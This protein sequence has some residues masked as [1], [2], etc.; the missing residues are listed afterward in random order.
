MYCLTI[1]EMTSILSSSFKVFYS[2]DGTLCGSVEEVLEDFRFLIDASSDLGLVLNTR[3]C[4][5]IRNDENTVSTMLSSL[6]SLSTV[7]PAEAILLAVLLQSIQ[8]S[9][10]RSKLFGPWG[11]GSSCCMHDALCL[12]QHALA[13]SKVTLRTAP[14]YQSSLLETFDNVLQS[15]LESICNIQLQLN[16]DS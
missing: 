13:I 16:A 8:S 11:K 6:P 5:V 15:L 9:F 4:E 7:S 10:Q 2:D 1:P 14:C 3:K 12:L